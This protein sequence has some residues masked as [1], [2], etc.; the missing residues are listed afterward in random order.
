MYLHYILNTFSPE[1]I[2]FYLLL[3][4]SI[5]WARMQESYNAY[6]TYKQSMWRIIFRIITFIPI[7]IFIVL[8]WP[9]YFFGRLYIRLNG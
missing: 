7:G 2:C 5:A 4:I 1:Q 9:V 8:F 3:G 6:K